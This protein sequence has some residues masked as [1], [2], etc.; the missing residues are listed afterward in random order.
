SQCAKTIVS[1][2]ARRAY[3]RPVT[4]V[5]LEGPLTFYR[6]GQADGGFEAGIEMALRA[7]LV[8]PRFLFRIEEDPKGIRPGTVY[9]ISDFELASRLSFFLWSSIPDD[10]LLNVAAAGALRSPEI[11][12]R[13]VRRLL[14]DEKSNALVENFAGQWLQLRNLAAVSPFPRAFPEFDDNLRQAFRRET[15]LFFS[16]IKDENRSVLDLFRANYTFLNERLAKHYGIPNVYGSRFRRVELTEDNPR[17]GLLGHGSLLTVTSYATRTAPTLRGKWILENILGSPPPPPP[18][19]V[20][21]L[22]ENKTEGKL[23]SMRERLAQHRTNPSCSGCHQL[24]DPVGLSLEN[25]D[26]TGRWRIA[27][28]NSP[29]NAA[30][31]LTDGIEFEGVHGLRDALLK[32]PEPFL[33]TITGKLLTYALGRSPEYYDASAIRKIVRD[34]GK[35]NYQFESIVLGI[36]QSTPFQMRRSR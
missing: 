13:Q 31:A 5:D 32:R 35:N 2:L 36:V 25:F 26:A 10:E 4:D 34:A 18:A 6:L 14:A 33:R 16:S 7:I 12:A 28:G 29:I 22:E 27:E 15:E 17:R 11:L 21:P 24:M 23:L 8:S 1:T 3:R 20:P 30:G 19:N 9:R